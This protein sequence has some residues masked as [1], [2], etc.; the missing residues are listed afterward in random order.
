M[1]RERSE[2]KEDYMGDED[3]ASSGSN[4]ASNSEN[5]RQGEQL[6]VLGD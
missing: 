5:E 4:N 2:Q 3:I 1:E 6:A